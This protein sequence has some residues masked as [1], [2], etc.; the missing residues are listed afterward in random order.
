[1]SRLSSSLRSVA[2]VLGFS[3]L[4]AAAGLSVAWPHTTYADGE[5][6]IQQKTQDGVKMG[7]CVVKAQ[8][9]RD[10]ASKTGW[11]VIVV[12]SNKGDGNATVPLEAD[13]TR[14]VASPM[15]RVAPY[16]AT[17][18]SS[19]DT[20]TLAAHQQV[21][22]RYEVPAKIA[23]GVDQA[24]ALETSQAKQPAGARTRITYAVMVKQTQAAPTQSAAP[25]RAEAPTMG[26]VQT[27][28]MQQ[29]Q[30]PVQQAAAP[31]PVMPIVN[32]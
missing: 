31:A 28:Q 2:T 5:N 32:F 23:E 1:M 3:M 30:A 14:T 22:R 16:P 13:L 25:A 29:M 26:Q 24:K 12:A 20:I 11:F 15:A 10:H 7:D 18:W 8:L 9:V 19:N 17:V 4:T 6:G 21:V 27:Q